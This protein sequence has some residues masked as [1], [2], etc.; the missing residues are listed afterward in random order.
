M[1]EIKDRKIRGEFIDDE[2]FPNMG[3]GLSAVCKNILN[4]GEFKERV[5]YLNIWIRKDSTVWF[6]LQRYELGGEYLLRLTLEEAVEYIKKSQETLSDS[7]KLL[8]LMAKKYDLKHP[9]IYLCKE[10]G[11]IMRLTDEEKMHGG[12]CR[13]CGWKYKERLKDFG[14][15][16]IKN[17]RQEETKE[18]AG[19]GNTWICG[20]SRLLGGPTP[21]S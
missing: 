17:K 13:K 20:N 5:E 19:Q 15:A 7:M 9:E 4:K 16:S 10:C 14:K 18:G 1:E 12:A 6:V 21:W 3:R 2:T 8:T 11:A